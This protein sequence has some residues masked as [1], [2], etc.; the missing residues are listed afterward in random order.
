MLWKKVP[1]MSV[2]KEKK[3]DDYVNTNILES[4]N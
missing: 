2:Q 3:G 4:E 1:L